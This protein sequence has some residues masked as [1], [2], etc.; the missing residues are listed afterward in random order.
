MFAQRPV[1]ERNPHAFSV[2]K[3]FGYQNLVVGGCSFTYNNSESHACTWP[4]YLKDFGNFKKVYDCSL[5]GAGNYHI[6]HSLKWAL[7]TE[8]LDPTDTL[9][10]AMFSG[11]DRDDVICSTNSLNDYSMRHLYTRHAVSGITGGCDINSKGNTKQGLDCVKHIKDKHSRAIENY[12]YIDSLKAW[13][14]QKGYKSIF[15][16][17]LDRKLPHRTSDFDIREYLPESCIIRLD[18]IFVACANI[19]GFALRNNLLSDDDLHPS[20]DGH[21]AW[22]KKCLIPCLESLNI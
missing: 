5:P 19:Y 16:D 18:E 10:I 6:S 22:T 9:V 17:Y 13:L 2:V 1:I 7:T 11:N 12:L 15:L 3:D 20:P 21:L 8:P 4:Y 14:D